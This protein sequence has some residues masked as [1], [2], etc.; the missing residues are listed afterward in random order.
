MKNWIMPVDWE[1]WEM[2]HFGDFVSNLRGSAGLSLE[3]LAILVDSSKS[4]LSRL[5]NDDIPQP[6]KG[7]TRKLVIAL[8]EILCTSK[9]ETKRYLELAGID[10]SLLT[11]AEEI[12]LGFA[13]SI[14]TNPPEETGTLERLERTYKQL[15][16]QLEERELRLGISSSP[17]NL[18]VK[19]QEYTNIL[20]EI[21]KKL[22]KMYDRQE[23]SEPD[24][25]Q[26]IPVH[27]AEALEGKIVV[28]HQHGES[29]HASL[30]SYSLY[31]LASPNARWL[32]QLADVERFAVDDCIIL[33]NSKN[34]EG[35]SHDEIKTTVLNTRLP[36]PDDL[37]KLKQEK[38]PSIEK[39]YFNSSH[40]RLVSFTPSFSDLERLEVTLA[41]LGFHEYYSLTPF[42]DEPLLTTLDGS[43]ASIRQKYGNT[44]LTYSSTDRGTSLIPTPVSIQCV[45]VTKDQQILLMRRSSSVAF[46]PNH[47]SASFE[48][49]MNAPGTDRK[50]NPSRS[51]DADFFAGAIR[52][53]DEEFAIPASA[54]E[55]IKVLSLNTEYLTLSVDVITMIKL[56]LTAEEI[57]ESWLLKAWDRDEASKFALLSTDLTTVVN[58][59]FS[60][61]LWHP[62][63]RMR[64]IQFL[65]HTY[66]VD[67]VAAAI[68]TKKDALEV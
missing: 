7:S 16:R 8:A 27:Y 61:T 53:L 50:G 14:P 18:K 6:F 9:K 5:E 42:F 55:S 43:K 52:G 3:E 23:P 54:V 31:S 11:E 35:W 21:Q 62:T 56:S 15:L 12:Q 1:M 41:P 48:E 65:F 66:G 59:L 36:I 29:L 19:I 68:K 44:A 26:A 10:Q 46:Y 67:E 57:R 33:T 2:K 64:L 40:Y 49:T 51:D 17:P 22:D 60:R 4:T 38:L 25:V 37:E 58:K 63:A 39:D 47:W 20:Q 30:R 32:M 24:L 28:G 34:F 13:L 45:V